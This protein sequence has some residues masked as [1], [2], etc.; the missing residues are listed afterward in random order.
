MEEWDGEILHEQKGW[1]RGS[2]GVCLKGAN[3]MAMSALGS[4]GPWLALGGPLFC[5][6]VA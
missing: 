6:S 3:S 1:D 2:G 5:L 4:R